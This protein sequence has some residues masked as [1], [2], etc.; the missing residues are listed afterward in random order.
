MLKVSR[1]T[2]HDALGYPIFLGA[3]VV[4]C[5]TVGDNARLRWGK[6]TE[7][8]PIK[9]SVKITGGNCTRGLWRH[10]S[11]IMV[12]MLPRDLDDK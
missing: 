8:D 1:E 3:Q 6:V 9:D 11:E 5:V 10:P 2:N 4:S 7:Y 12:L